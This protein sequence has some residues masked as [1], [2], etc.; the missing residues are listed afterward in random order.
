MREEGFDP[1]LQIPRPIS[2]I[3]Q[4]AVLQRLMPA[5]DLALRLRMEGRAADMSDSAL[6]EPAAEITGDV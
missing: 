1:H 2:M 6:F 5:F 3:E 4:D